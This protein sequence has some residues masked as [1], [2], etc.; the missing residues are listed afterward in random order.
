MIEFKQVYKSYRELTIFR[1]ISLTLEDDGIV[2]VLGDNGSGKTT[3][4]NILCNIIHPDSGDYFFDGEKITKRSKKFRTR[5]GAVLS[6]PIFIDELSVEKYLEFVCDFQLISGD[7]VKE[8][9]DFH[10]NWLN[11][12]DKKN[13]KIKKI[14]SDE[15]KKVSIIS[16]LLHQPNVLFWD[17]PFINLD[18]K[19][20]AKILNFIGGKNSPNL[21]LI[22]TH[23]IE[24]LK[25]IAAKFIIIEYEDIRIVNNNNAKDFKKVDLGELMQ[26]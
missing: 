1:D 21:I 11:I 19:S 6:E 23:N 15:K 8:R 3:L 9:I 16:S 22:A 25:N 17:E 14:S 24:L 7:S 10:L 5:F 2:A 12:R 20:I 26:D 4:L 13:T 18:Q